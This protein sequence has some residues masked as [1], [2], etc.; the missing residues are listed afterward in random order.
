[1]EVNA[2]YGFS[3]EEI[4]ETIAAAGYANGGRVGLSN[5]GEPGIMGNPAYGKNLKI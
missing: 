1:M 5:G 4:E 2:G 3:E